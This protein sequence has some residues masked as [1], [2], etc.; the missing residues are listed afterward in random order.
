MKVFDRDSSIGSDF[1]GGFHYH[2]RWSVMKEIIQKQ[3]LPYIFHMS[4]TIN[5]DNKKKFYE[6]LGEWYLHERCVHK[7]ADDIKKIS[8]GTDNVDIVNTCCSLEPI[9]TCHY[10]DKPSKSSCNDS[11]NI[12]QR[13]KPFW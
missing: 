8:T 3:R 11:P 13:G 1:P 6:Q 4:W 12:D 5:K 7:T 2:K 9:I 10:K